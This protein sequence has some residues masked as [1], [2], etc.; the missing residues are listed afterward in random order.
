MRIEGREHDISQSVDLELK[1]RGGAACPRRRGAVSWPLGRNAD[2]Q[3]GVGVLR[4]E[5][6][7]KYAVE[8]EA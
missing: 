4:A 7:V 3:T 6:L 5:D 2:S 8:K 1:A